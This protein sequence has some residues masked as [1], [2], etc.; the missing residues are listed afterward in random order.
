MSAIYVSAYCY[1]CVLIRLYMCPHTFVCVL[2]LVHV[3]AYCYMCVRVLHI[4]AEEVQL[5]T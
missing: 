5:Y 3:S 2:I 4:Q 1:A